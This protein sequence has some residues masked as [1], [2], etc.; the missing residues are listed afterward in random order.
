MVI[1]LFYCIIW[2]VNTIAIRDDDSEDDGVIASTWN[3]RGYDVG[4]MMFFL[5]MDGTTYT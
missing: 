5:P 3:C 1:I 2:M 4:S